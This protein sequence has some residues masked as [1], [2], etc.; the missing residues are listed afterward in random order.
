MEV[1]HKIWMKILY[2]IA[3]LAYKYRYLVYVVCHNEYRYR[4]WRDRTNIVLTINL[5]TTKSW[6]L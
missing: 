3:K 5:Y 6:N 2:K 1:K 4:E